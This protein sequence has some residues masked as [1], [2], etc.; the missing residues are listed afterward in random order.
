M[1]RFSFVFFLVFLGFIAQ[2]QSRRQSASPQPTPTNTED[3]TVISYLPE[4][5]FYLN[6]DDIA[7]HTTDLILFSVAPNSQGNLQY[8]LSGKHYM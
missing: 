3:F 8:Y 5:R 6:V 1:S 7:L 4:Y 2:V